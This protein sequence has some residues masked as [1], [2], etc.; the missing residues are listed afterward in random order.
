MKQKKIKFDI[1]AIVLILLLV[2]IG[3]LL[4]I[5]RINKIKRSNVKES[6]GDIDHTKI[7]EIDDFLSNEECDKLMNMA[8]PKL[9]DSLVYG[10]EK[11]LKENVHRTSKQAWIYNNEDKLVDDISNRVAKHTNLPVANQEPLQIVNYGVGGFFNPHYDPCVGEDKFCERMNGKSGKRHCT[12]LI[13][14]NDVEEGGQTCFTKLNK[15]IEPKKGK[16]VIF[17]S[18]ENDDK[19]IDTSEHAAMPVKKGEKWVC[20]KWVHLKEY[21][22]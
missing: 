9:E 8:K 6:F 10:G 14:L 19:L 11:D 3:L 13:Y 22:N 1:L 20:N 16:A 4:I 15:C 17:Y 18:T 2:G 21:K 5:R 12:V 7:Y